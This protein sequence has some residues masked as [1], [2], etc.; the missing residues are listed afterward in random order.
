METVD[1]ITTTSK[2]KVLRTLSIIAFMQLIGVTQMNHVK[3]PKPDKQDFLSANGK[4]VGAISRNYKKEL[5]VKEMIEVQFED[6][7]DPVWILHNPQNVE[8][9]FTV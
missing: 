7:T 1:T 4:T 6:T 3:N 2:P 5:P 9:T 8:E